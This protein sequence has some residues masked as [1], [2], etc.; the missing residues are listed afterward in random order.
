MGVRYPQNPSSAQVAGH[1]NGLNTQG[2]IHH[3]SSYQL[4][5]HAIFFGLPSFHILELLRVPLW[6]VEA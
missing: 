5:R 6:E 4:V 3:P 2:A 1:K